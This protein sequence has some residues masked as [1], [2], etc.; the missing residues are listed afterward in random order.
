MTQTAVKPKRVRVECDAPPPVSTIDASGVL[1]EVLLLLGTPPGMCQVT[2]NLTRATAVTQN[3]FRVNIY[4]EDV[5]PIY[6]AH[7]LKHSYFVRV[8]NTGSIVS[9]NP[10]IVKQ[11]K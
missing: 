5:R 10:E 9:S 11:Y 1:N 8:D 3:S 2:P 7:I 6:T 4:V